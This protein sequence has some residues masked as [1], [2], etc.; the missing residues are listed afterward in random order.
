LSQ[1]GRL[2]RKPRRDLLDE[3]P[4]D[5]GTILVRRPIVPMEEYLSKVDRERLK[6]WN[7]V[8]I[9]I[10]SFRADQMKATGGP[11]EV[12]PCLE[13]LA[14]EGRS[15]PDCYTQATHT[16]YAAPAVFSS[17]HPLRARFVHRY[18][19]DPAYPRVMIYD[20]L[21]ALG[22][23]TAFFSSQ[24]ELWGGMMNFYQTGGLEKVFHAKLPDLPVRIEA[25]REPYTQSLDDAVTI[26]E[27]MR[28]TEAV[29]DAPFFLYLNLQNAH[30]PFR[31]P[32]DFPRK[33]GP[34][35]AGF[36]ITAG[37]FPR[38]KVDVVRE[39]YADSLAYVDGQLE[40]LFNR[41]KERG[42]WDRTLVV[43]TGDHGEAFFEHGACAHAFSVYDEETRVPLVLRAP[44]LEPLRDPRPAQLIDVAPGIFHLLGL[45]IHPSFQGIDLVGPAPRPDRIRP[46]ICQTGFKTLL[47]AVGSGFKLIRSAE[48]GSTVLH[49]LTRDPHERRDASS[50]HPEV[51]K[52]LRS[53][54]K[55]W[56]WAQ[57]EYYENPGRWSRE[58][59]PVVGDP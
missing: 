27:A 47:G 21:K 32:P 19:K 8:V 38:E 51:A 1:T 20:V 4:P 54:L 42:L 50:E 28:W 7:V 37:S 58:Y 30:L 57:V 56:R 35:T 10:D 16:D 9:L 41:F 26:D 23:R 44:G 49:D 18:P 25:T 40:R 52:Q 55:T 53:W 2:V 24:D 17:H 29:P 43:V 33:F 36:T 6:R 15:Y 31:V 22:W 13:A 39:I 11:R 48:T 14:R 59:P 34:S 12:M 3:G 45:P 5:E 46:M